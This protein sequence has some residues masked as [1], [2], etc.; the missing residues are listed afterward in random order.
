MFVVQEQLQSEVV[1]REK[2]VSELERLASESQVG[3]A[4]G[5]AS[6]QERESEVERLAREVEEERGGRERLERDL[7]AAAGN[8]EETERVL[9][10][11]VSLW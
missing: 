9:S 4:E 2:Q 3:V 6:L 1:L 11:E 7:A 5:V 10:E 8:K